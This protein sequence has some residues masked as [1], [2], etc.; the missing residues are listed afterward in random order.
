M[1][2]LIDSGSVCIVGIERNESV[3]ILG[4]SFRNNIV[5]SDGGALLVGQTSRT[6]VIRCDFED[7]ASCD[8]GG[9]S[10]IFQFDS[11]FSRSGDVALVSE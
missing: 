2:N 3:E 4:C 5:Q 10:I 6:D 7:N 9:G 11:I 8:G 1:S